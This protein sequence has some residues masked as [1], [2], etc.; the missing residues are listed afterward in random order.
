MLVLCSNIS[1]LNTSVISNPT[2]NTRY[3]WKAIQKHVLEGFEQFSLTWRPL[4]AFLKPS[5]GAWE[6]WLLGGPRVKKSTKIFFVP[7]QSIMI[8]NGPKTC[9]IIIFSTFLMVFV[10]FSVLRRCGLHTGCTSDHASTSAISLGKLSP[11]LVPDPGAQIKS[12]EMWPKTWKY[13]DWEGFPTIW[14]HFQ[15]IWDKI[16]FRFFDPRT[17]KIDPLGAGP[18]CCRRAWWATWAHQFCPERKETTIDCHF[19][20]FG[21]VWKHIGPFRAH[22]YMTYAYLGVQFPF[23]RKKTNKISKTGHLHAK[24]EQKKPKSQQRQLRGTQKKVFMQGGL[25]GMKIET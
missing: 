16:F 2:H 21:R 14:V 13:D 10:H 1:G 24:S 4:G 15:V 22:G 17:P 19:L 8:Q 23:L 25:I 12:C 5:P 3:A 9:L 20:G 18:P 6:R 11:V 7:N